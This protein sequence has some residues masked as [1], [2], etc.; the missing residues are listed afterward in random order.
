M[1]ALKNESRM[2]KERSATTSKRAPRYVTPATVG[3]AREDR[4]KERYQV[5]PAISEGSRRARWLL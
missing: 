5:P 3:E 1:G 2:Q 4:L